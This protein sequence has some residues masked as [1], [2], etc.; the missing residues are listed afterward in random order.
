MSYIVRES[1]GCC[2]QNNDREVYKTKNPAKRLRQLFYD[3]LK[4]AN[5]TD[6]RIEKIKVDVKEYGKYE[7]EHCGFNEGNAWVDFD[8]VYST[9]TYLDVVQ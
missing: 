4:E 1:W 9:R 2:R 5:F 8:D 3:L 6:D 7:D